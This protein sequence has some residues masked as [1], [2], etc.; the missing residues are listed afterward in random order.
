MSSIRWSVVLVLFLVAGPM[1]G[2]VTP[3]ESIVLD[4]WEL[5]LGGFFTRLDTTLQGRRP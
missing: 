2:A 3:D 1:F 5:Q 4:R